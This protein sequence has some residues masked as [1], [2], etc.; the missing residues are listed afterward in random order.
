MTKKKMMVD[1]T[2]NRYTFYGGGRRC[3]RKLEYLQALD[4]ALHTKEN[5]AIVGRNYSR[6]IV[7]ADW[8]RK[9]TEKE[10]PKKVINGTDKESG[11]RHYNECPS[12]GNRVSK[13]DKYCCMCGQSLDWSDEE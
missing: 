13:P 11:Y 5:I 9:Q 4:D 3:N 2:I 8:Y 10:T 12:C 6:V 7:N 1:D